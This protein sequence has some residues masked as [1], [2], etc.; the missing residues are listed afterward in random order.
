MIFQLSRKAAINLNCENFY[1]EPAKKFNQPAIKVK[2]QFK[3]RKCKAVL[4]IFS[5]GQFN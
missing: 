1:L 5:L 4:V 3:G 2:R